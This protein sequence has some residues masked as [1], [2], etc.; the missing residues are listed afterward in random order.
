MSIA[1][2]PEGPTV[3]SQDPASPPQVPSYTA[4]PTTS[5]REPHRRSGVVGGLILIAIGA[6]AL[7]SMWFPGGGAWLFL[8]LGVA[9][10]IARVLTGRYGYAVP[11]GILLGFGSFV[12]FTEVG[13]LNGPTAGG[14][15]FVFLGLGFLAS[16]AIAARP[17]AVWP[18]LPGVVLVGF[19]AFIQGTMFG[20]PF[21][22]YW[23]LAQYW[24]LTLVAVGAWLLL[25]DQLP[26]AARTPVAI[27][28]ASA[29][30]LVGL[31]VAAAGMA[32]VAAPYY[33]RGPMPMSWPMSWTGFGTAPLQDTITLSAP[34]AGI[35]SIR[36]V[37]TAGTTVVRPA[38]GSEVTVQAT[39]HFFNNAQAPDV[40]LVPTSGVLSI[41]STSLAFVGAGSY[42]DYVIDT[43]AGLGADIRSASGPITVSGLRGPVHAES[44]S[45]SIDARDLQGS[46]VLR[47]AS[48]G[49]RMANISGDLQVTSVSGG[50]SGAG[51]DRAADIRSTSGGINLT[52]AFATNAQIVT[53]S[54][55]VVLRFTPAAAVRIDAS[56]LSGDVNASELDLNGRVGGARSLSGNLGSAF[57]TVTVRTTS[58]GIHL[59]P[60]V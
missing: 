19:G 38:Q 11:A 20:A 28:G 53:V 43:P 46:T 8:G 5:D 58:G 12:W 57:S 1:S 47:T 9:F 4:P 44:A 32:T 30:I 54:G 49:I 17:Q 37:N 13:M 22:Q 16:Y 36:L 35:D 24:P 3:A 25:R 52:G 41:Q 50:I 15:F 18:I 48:G 33:A 60:S 56:T 39:R 23:W 29:L 40:Q 27:V 31:L 45:G 14:M 42:V 51:V 21:S 34:A 10:A 6:I 26:P 2:P 59:M 7:G 55:A